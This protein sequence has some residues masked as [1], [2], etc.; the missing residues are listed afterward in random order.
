MVQEFKG[1]ELTRLKYQL[2]SSTI[3]N[4]YMQ[5]EEEE[6]CI[7]NCQIRIHAKIFIYT[8]SGRLISTN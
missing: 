1:M 3:P 8:L 7:I 4:G 5:E 2:T 6:A